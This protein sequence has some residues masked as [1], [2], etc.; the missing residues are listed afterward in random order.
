MVAATGTN[1]ATVK[2]LHGYDRSITED[3]LE[4]IPLANPAAVTPGDEIAFKIVLKG[5]PLAGQKVAVIRRSTSTFEEYE[6]DQQGVIRFK[7]GEPDYY[8][9]RLEYDNPQEQKPGEY[10]KTTYEAT[11]TY[12][13]Q[14]GVP[15]T[16]P[17]NLAGRIPAWGW[18]VAGGVLGV[19]GTALGG[20]GR[21]R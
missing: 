12:I 4:I 17:G 13:V 14:P 21:R 9:I 5:Q 8:M 2:G 6:T 15:E 20:L 11:F 16:Q 10:A 1:P 7:A 18:L 19:A 3:R